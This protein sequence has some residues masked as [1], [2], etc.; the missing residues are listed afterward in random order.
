MEYKD[1]IGRTGLTVRETTAG[2]RAV[3]T[4]PHEVIDDKVFDHVLAQLPG[5]FQEMVEITT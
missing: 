1:F 4:T 5:E 2:V 3:L